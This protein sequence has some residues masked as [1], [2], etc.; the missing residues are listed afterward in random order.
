M[1]KRRACSPRRDLVVEKSTD[2]VQFLEPI[3]STK[4]KEE[5][6]LC[7]VN[8]HEKIPESNIA[9]FLS[10]LVD[11]ELDAYGCVLPP[12]LQQPDLAV[13]SKKSKS[14]KGDTA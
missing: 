13:S 5:I 3:L 9:A 12:P 6:A 2:F 14:R 10:P 7:L 4:K 1:S 11:Q 8:I